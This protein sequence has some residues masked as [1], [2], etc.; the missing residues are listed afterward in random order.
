MNYSNE[1]SQ[2]ANRKRFAAL[3]IGKENVPSNGCRK[4]G[5][6]LPDTST[7]GASYRTDSG[8]NEEVKSDT[9]GTDVSMQLDSSEWPGDT[10]PL[11]DFIG[12]SIPMATIADGTVNQR[13]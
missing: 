7:G 5:E 2:E 8:F 13:R 10:A 6:S 12:R 11:E 1:L 9:V 3:T 4:L